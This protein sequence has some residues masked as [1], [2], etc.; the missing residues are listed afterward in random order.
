M[1]KK[2]ASSGAGGR[3][4][5]SERLEMRGDKANAVLIGISSSERGTRR[6][7]VMLLKVT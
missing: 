6:L 7:K 5:A 2:E 1:P 3:E 4:D